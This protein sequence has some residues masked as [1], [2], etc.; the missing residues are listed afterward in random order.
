MRLRVDT[1]REKM[2][3]YIYEMKY[4]LLYFVLIV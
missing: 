2:S 4:T 3:E 1:P